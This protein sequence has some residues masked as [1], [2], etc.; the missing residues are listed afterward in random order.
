MMVL[1][2]TRWSMVAV[3]YVRLGGTLIEQKTV[4]IGDNVVGMS[5]MMLS[6]FCGVETHVIYL[7]NVYST[8]DGAWWIQDGAYIGY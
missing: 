5:G 7:R 1:G 2:G 8:C 4:K 3:G 6:E